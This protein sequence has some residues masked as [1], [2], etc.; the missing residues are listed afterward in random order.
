MYGHPD[1]VFSQ[2]PDGHTFLCK[3]WHFS[4]GCILLTIGSIYT[5]RGDFVK[6]GLHF[7][8][9]SIRIRIV[10]KSIVYRLVP[11]PSRYENRQWQ[12]SSPH[13]SRSLTPFFP[14]REES[15]LREE[16]VAQESNTV[17]PASTQKWN[18]RSGVLLSN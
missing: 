3:F 2:R 4:N 12:V 6:L 11:S 7:M 10:A 1:A 15:N 17:I 8:T 14:R 16:C 9:I 18:S 5:K 13:F